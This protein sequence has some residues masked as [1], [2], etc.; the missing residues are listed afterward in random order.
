MRCN[1]YTGGGLPNALAND[2]V[3]WWAIGACGLDGTHVSNV[4]GT[5]E[6]AAKPL[7]SQHH[8]CGWIR[9][10]RACASFFAMRLDT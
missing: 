9:E 6:T 1:G 10:F 5:L 8:I 2:D 3:A 4:L 7:D